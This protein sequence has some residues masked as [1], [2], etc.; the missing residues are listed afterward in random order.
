MLIGF[1]VG[2]GYFFVADN[3]VGERWKNCSRTSGARFARV[4]RR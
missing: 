2:L 3:T 1:G 4:K